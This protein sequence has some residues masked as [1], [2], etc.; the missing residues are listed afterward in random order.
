MK[1]QAAYRWL[2]DQITQR[3]I[4]AFIICPLIEASDK[5]TMKQAKAATVEYEKQKK[6]FPG[7]KIGLLH[8]RLKNKEKEE[9]LKK[10]RQGKIDILVSTPVV[11]V[12][13]DVANATIMVIEAAERFGLAQ[14]HQL[15][16]RVGRGSKKSHCLLFTEL[17]SKKVNTRLSAL[18]ENLS[19]FEL[20]ELD[21][22][23]RGPGEIL[24]LKQ[25][26]FSE[27]KIASWQDTRLI[28][29]ARVLAQEIAENPNRYPQLGK[30]LNLKKIVFN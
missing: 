2:K 16:G 28:K 6:L 25:H 27:L 1:R 24:G 8:G 4:Q 10:F 29:K 20:A 12:G 30:Y 26:G 22:K 17:K 3:Q 13:I 18:K 21:L 23:L 5:E 7:L 19:G 11:E 15:R 9:N 14:L